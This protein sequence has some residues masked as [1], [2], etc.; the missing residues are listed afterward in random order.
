[1]SKLQR[2]KIRRIEKAISRLAKMRLIYKYGGGR[3]STHMLNPAG[4]GLGWSDC[5]GLAQYLC[6]VGDIHLKNFVGSTWSLAEEGEAGK[7]DLFTLFIKNNPGDEHVIIRVRKR[8][9][10]W[11]RGETRYRWAECGGTDNPT[12]G[13]GPTWF[14]P[15]PDRIKEFPIHRKFVGL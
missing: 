12:S 1:M 11:H 3:G 8:P 6:E 10:P 7:S 14:R 4:P 5:S 9:R 13:G 2:K 15:T